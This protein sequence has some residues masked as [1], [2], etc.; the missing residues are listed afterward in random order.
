MTDLHTVQLLGHADPDGLV[1]TDDVLV[2]GHQRLVLIAV[3]VHVDGGFL[4]FG[5]LIVGLAGQGEVHA[6]GPVLVVG[7]L[8]AAVFE[9]LEGQVVGAQHH[10]LRRHGDGATVLGTQQVV[11]GQHQQTRLGLCFGG[12]RNV[13][14][15]LVAV[16]VGV[17]GRAVQGMQ[18]QGAALHQHR[19][20]GLNAQ[21][22]Q[23]RCTVQHD[24]VVLDDLVQRVPHLGAALVHHLLGGLDVVGAAILHQLLHNEGTEQLHSHLLGHAALVDL[25]LGADHDNAS[26]GVVHA[27]TQQVLAETALLALEHIAQGLEGAVVGAGDRAA[28]AAVVDQG[29]HRLL[30]HTLLVADDDIGGLQLHQALQAVV[31]V[32]DPAVQVVQVAGGETAAVQLHHG[33]D[34][35]RDDGQHIDDH[36]LRLVA[37]QAEGVHH[38]KALDDAGLFLAGGGLQLGVQ[39]LAQL[40]QIDLLQQLL[41]GLGAHAG[42]EVVLILLAHI[43]V[44]LLGEDL[45]LGQRR[46]AGI[47]DDIGGEV[48]HLLQDTG[49]DVQ[50]QSHTGGDT[51]EVPDV[52]DGGSQLNVAHTLAADLGT[53]DFHAAAVAD[54]ALVADLLILTAVALPVLRRPENA[55]TEQA[56]ALG[57]QS[58][59]VDGLGLL[60]LAVGPL[61]DHFRRSNADLDGIKGCVTHNSA[62]PFP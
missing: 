26:A 8:A 47:G 9:A 33:T 62:P 7:H 40:L 1:D 38:L 17:E 3:D 19:L 22:V 29:V 30:K 24:G 59:V 6:L 44:F 48:Q 16:E 42:A 46:L 28:A 13:D 56:V 4:L 12:Q 2:V 18:L 35:R 50:Q 36:P 21:A 20:K 14:S 27:L 32:D 37:G 54:L 15:H 53:G 5:K 60:Y 41:H 55:L 23:R 52:T 45:V 57:L 39:L 43:A 51:L 34:L 61:A 10:I 31:A 25:Q 11:G 49:A 58:T